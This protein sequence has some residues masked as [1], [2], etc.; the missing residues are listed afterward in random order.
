MGKK[1]VSKAEGNRATC[2]MCILCSP[3]KAL[4]DVLKDKS[5]SLVDLL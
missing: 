4:K 1:S 2:A 5:Q 3:N